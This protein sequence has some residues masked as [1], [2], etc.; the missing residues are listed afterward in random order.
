MVGLGK[1]L[2][3]PNTQENHHHQTLILRRVLVPINMDCKIKDNIQSK[4]HQRNKKH[5]NLKIMGDTL[6]MMWLICEDTNNK[7]DLTLAT[8][9]LKSPQLPKIISKTKMPN[10][11]KPSWWVWAKRRNQPLKTSQSSS[12][13]KIS[14]TNPSIMIWTSKNKKPYTNKPKETKEDIDYLINWVQD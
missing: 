1:V 3:Q 5:G 7:S 4:N 6:K 13:T 12:T 10:S 8:I 14:W 9:T 11:K 2:Q